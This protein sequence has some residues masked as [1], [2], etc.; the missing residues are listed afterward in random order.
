MIFLV[1]KKK[2]CI[3]SAKLFAHFTFTVLFT[4]FDLW[5]FLTPVLEIL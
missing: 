1:Y 4:V 3:Y 5:E 2:I